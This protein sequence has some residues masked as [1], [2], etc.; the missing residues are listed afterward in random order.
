MNTAFNTSRRGFLL[1]S[2]ALSAAWFLLGGCSRSPEGS[3]GG[4]TDQYDHF[5]HHVS[6]ARDIGHYYL[7][8]YPDEAV[9]EKM[10]RQVEDSLGEVPSDV[11]SDEGKFRH[12]V[13][14]KIRSDFKQG[15][16]VTLDGWVLS[17]T[18]ARLCALLALRAS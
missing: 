15:K 9:T 17:E 3:A 2:V 1:G 10:Q 13:Q 4:T 16:T 7:E 14:E 5:F 8:V 11:I 12:F 18:E 6:E